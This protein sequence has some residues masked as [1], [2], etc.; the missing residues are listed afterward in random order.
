MFIQSGIKILAIFIFKRLTEYYKSDHASLKFSG[1]SRC[2]NNYHFFSDILWR[3]RVFPS[4]YG[5]FST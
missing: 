2:F 1:F 3:N 4:F 5:L